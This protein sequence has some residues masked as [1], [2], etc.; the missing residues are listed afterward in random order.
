[1]VQN[2]LGNT[3]NALGAA[4]NDTALFK[5]A[6][7]AFRAALEVRTRERMPLQWAASQLNLG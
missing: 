3:L 1:M 4:R 5:K 6:A 7:D 2:N